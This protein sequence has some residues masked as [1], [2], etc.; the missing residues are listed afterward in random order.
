MDDKGIHQL[1][2]QDNC[3]MWGDKEG[4]LIAEDSHMVDHQGGEHQLPAEGDRGHLQERRLEDI[5]F[6]GD[7]K[8]KARQMED[9]LLLG[10]LAVVL[11]TRT[12]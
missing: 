9:I 5:Y 2:D 12:W 8:G 6:V 7:V 3:R 10:H 4:G 1:V 11:G